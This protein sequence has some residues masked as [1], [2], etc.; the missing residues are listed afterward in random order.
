MHLTTRHLYAS[1]S[2]V[3]SDS[4]DLL[5]QQTEFELNKFKYLR[6]TITNVLS[7]PYKTFKLNKLTKN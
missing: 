6:Y 7:L 5:L 1:D 2:T 4:Q 3:H